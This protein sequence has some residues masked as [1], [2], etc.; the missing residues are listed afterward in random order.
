MYHEAAFRVGA[1]DADIFGQ[2]R[3]SA[4][5]DFL[6]EAATG[7]AIALHVSREETLRD[8]GAFWM[9]ARIWYRLEEP[10]LWDDRLTVQ[11]WHRGDGHGP[12]MYRDFDI[13]RAGRRIGEG[14]SIWVLADA[15]TRRLRRVSE[16]P[17]FRETTGG[18]RCK[19][20]MLSKL[21]PPVPLETAGTR[22]LGYSDCDVNGHVNNI[23]YADYVLTNSFHAMAF[24]I[25][26]QKKF[27]TFGH[28]TRN[29][30]LENVLEQCALEERMVRSGAEPHD[31]DA[32]I[33]W[34]KVKESMRQMRK[35]SILFLKPFLQPWFSS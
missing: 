2:C 21:R 12:S 20:R 24:S 18:E 25:I 7:A 23:H 14:V 35:N 4:M 33:D 3:P 26:Y 34:T 6:Q 16:L 13:F 8:Y 32:V 17:G 31:I 27:L 10:V 5:M 19:S 22:Q 11:T 29:A 30:R 1:R 15:E 9:L 28:S